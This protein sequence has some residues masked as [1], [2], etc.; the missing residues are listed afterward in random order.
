MSRGMAMFLL[1][2]ICDSFCR[3]ESSILIMILSISRQQTRNVCTQMGAALVTRPNPKQVTKS[4]YKT[5][6]CPFLC[7]I[8]IT[9]LY[10]FN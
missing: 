4:I 6:M 9:I 2:A 8:V 7:Q 1:A 3:M 5:Q 10:I